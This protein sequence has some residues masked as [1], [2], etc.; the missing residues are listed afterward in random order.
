MIWTA[1]KDKHFDFDN[2]VWITGLN[3]MVGNQDYYEKVDFENDWRFCEV[4]NKRKKSILIGDCELS[5]S[6]F[7]IKFPLTL[8]NG[9]IV[10]NGNGNFE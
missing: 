2:H 10:L 7:P 8:K 4:K 6:D 1:F 5:D 9:L 3:F